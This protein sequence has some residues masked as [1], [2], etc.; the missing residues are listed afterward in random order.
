MWSDGSEARGFLRADNQGRLSGIWTAFLA[1]K[2]RHLKVAT[3]G[4]VGR[5][6]YRAWR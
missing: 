3:T 5:R 1:F 6:L 2:Y 4:E